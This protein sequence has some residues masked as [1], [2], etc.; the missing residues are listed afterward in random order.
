MQTTTIYSSSQAG[1][2]EVTTPIEATYRQRSAEPMR[3]IVGELVAQNDGRELLLHLTLSQLSEAIA[4][5]LSSVKIYV[6]ESDI[7]QAQRAVKAVVE[8]SHF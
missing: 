8:E 4:A 6:L 7:S 1:S 2:V 3:P 5:A